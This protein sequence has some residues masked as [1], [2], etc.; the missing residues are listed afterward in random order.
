MWLDRLPRKTDVISQFIFAKET[1][2]A[3]ADTIR[4]TANAVKYIWDDADVP[5]IGV[6]MIETAIYDLF[7]EIHFQ[8][9]GQSEVKKQ[10]LPGKLFSLATKQP[11]SVY[12]R[13]FVSNYNTLA[14]VLISKNLLALF[15]ISLADEVEQNSF[16]HDQITHRKLRNEKRLG[17]ISMRGT[18]VYYENRNYG[19]ATPKGTITEYFVF[20]SGVL[21]TRLEVVRYVQS[22]T[23]LR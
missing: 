5:C 15:D 7:A 21:P 20:P 4:M 11:S 16:Y 18:D 10:F 14:N 9:T 8:A 2:M 1:Q 12:N 19:Q 23:T 22:R 17:Q 3:A 6:E 13:N